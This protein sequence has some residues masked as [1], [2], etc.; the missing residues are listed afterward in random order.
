LAAGSARQN[1]VR[2]IHA[3]GLLLF[4]QALTLTFASPGLSSISEGERQDA[5]EPGDIAVF[6]LA[7]SVIAGPGSLSAGVVG[8]PEWIDAAWVLLMLL[9]RLGLTYGAMFVAE[10]LVR[11][12]GRTG[13]DVVGRVSGSLL[14]DLAVQFV[15]DGLR[16]MF[17]RYR[18]RRPPK[19]SHRIPPGNLFLLS[20]TV[21]D[22]LAIGV[23]LGALAEEY[24]VGRSAV[25]RVEKRR[26]AAELRC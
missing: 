15:F 26:A 19:R 9:A 5:Q 12:L 11:R 16:Q 10:A 23:S 18:T 8:A 21:N 4:L 14:A 20:L 6:P 2:K 3:G 24:G 22:L 7:F 13:V 17:F 25:Q 1:K